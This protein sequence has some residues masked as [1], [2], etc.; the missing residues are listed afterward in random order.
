MLNK[1]IAFDLDGTLTINSIIDF[2]KKTP[3]E[4]EKI[5]IELLPN[6]KMIDILNCIAQDNLVYIFTARDDIY[7]DVTIKWLKRHGVNY[8][9]VIMKKPFYDILIDDSTMSPEEAVKLYGN[10]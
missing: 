9:F 10:V 2:K 3:E 8:K 4:M 6:L 7:Q 1:I 5:Y